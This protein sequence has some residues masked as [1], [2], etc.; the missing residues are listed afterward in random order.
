[1]TLIVITKFDFEKRLNKVSA[2]MLIQLLDNSLSGIRSTKIPKHLQVL[3]TLRFYAE[4]GLQ[5][6][7]AADF[8]HPVA[9]STISGIITR[10]T[11]CIIKLAD[12]FI[13]FPRTPEER[14]ATSH[15]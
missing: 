12:R 10:V 8:G 15:E 4:G 11:D 6:G 3:A 9:Q 14:Q 13:R 5:K 1:M 7:T 2:F